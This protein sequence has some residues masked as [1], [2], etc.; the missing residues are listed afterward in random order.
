MANCAPS[1]SLRPGHAAS[2][3]THHPGH[4]APSVKASAA[5]PKSAA[6]LHQLARLG[7]LCWK[8]KLSQSLQ[9]GIGQIIR[10]FQDGGGKLRAFILYK[11]TVS[12]LYRQLPARPIVRGS[13]SHATVTLR[14][15]PCSKPATT[16]GFR[17][18]ALAGGHCAQ[19][20]T[21]PEQRPRKSATT[22]TRNCA[23]K[24]PLPQ[25]VC[26]VV[27]TRRPNT[28]RRWQPPRRHDWPLLRLQ[29]P[30]RH[31]RRPHLPRQPRTRQQPPWRPRQR[32]RLRRLRPGGGGFRYPESG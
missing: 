9:F 13:G 6:S 8:L 31:P 11:Y 17:C 2:V 19:A 10:I 15:T 27:V 14:K 32:T 5:Y 29:L 22:P 21:L 30:Q 12:T 7:A 23:A 4:R 16:I 3:R 25:R 20:A 24:K 26:S 18:P 1:T 28:T